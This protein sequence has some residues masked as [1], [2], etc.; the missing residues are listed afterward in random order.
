MAVEVL[1]HNALGASCS[2]SAGT[3]PQEDSGGSG[4]LLDKDAQQK[5]QDASGSWVGINLC[6]NLVTIF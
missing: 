4:Q 3:E 6:L 1:Y 5:T 2:N